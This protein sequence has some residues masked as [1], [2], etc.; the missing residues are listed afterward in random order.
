MMRKIA[1]IG[2]DPGEK[3][4]LAC[5]SYNN[6]RF[7]DFDH[8]YGADLFLVR[9]KCKFDIKFA[10]LEK[11]WIWKNE[12]DV[13]SAEVLIRNSEMW[14]TLLKIHGIPFLQATPGSWRKGIIKGKPRKDKCMA[15]AKKLFPESVDLFTRH[16]RAEAALIAY[17]AWRHFNSGSPLE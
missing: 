3:G 11:V 2:I 15:K 9:L 12:K 16:D 4:S 6:L 14:I 10:V 5:L 8:T 7:Y 1:V 17:R 13:K